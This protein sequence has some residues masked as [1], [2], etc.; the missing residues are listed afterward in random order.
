MVMHEPSARDLDRLIRM[1]IS[2]RD[3]L[4]AGAIGMAMV[5]SLSRVH[6]LSPEAVEAQPVRGGTLVYAIDNVGSSNDPGIFANFG[7]WEA[8][9]CICR[10]LTFFDYQ[11]PGSKPQPALA[12]R[13]EISGDGRSYTFSLRKGLKFHDGT[14]LTA[15]SVKRS[16]VRLLDEKDPTRAPGTYAGVEIGGDNIKE[17][18]IVDESTVRLI[19][20]EPDEAQLLRLA[21][22]NAVILS[23]AALDKYGAKIGL[24][25]VGAGPFKFERMA[26]GQEIVLSAFDGYYGGRPYLDR[27]VLRAIPN[28]ATMISALEAGQ[29]HA[30]NFAPVSALP[31]FRRNPNLKIVLGAP[32]IVLFAGLNAKIPPLDNIKVRQ[33]INYAINRQAIIE[34]VFNG[35]ALPPAGMIAPA[36][37]G[38]DGS[39]KT[40]SSYQPEKAKQLLKESGMANPE[41]TLQIVN[42]Q[43]WPRLV[44]LVQKD[45]T[46]VGFKVNVLKLDGGTFWGKVFDGKAEVSLTQRSAFVADPDNK[47]TPLLYSTSSVAQKQTGNDA[48]PD[49]KNLDGLLDQAR[50]Q[51]DPAKR[52]QEYAQIQKWLL[53]RVPYV[54]LCYE[55]QP[56]VMQKNVYAINTAALGT[57]RMYLEKAYIRPS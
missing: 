49:A 17:V 8:I 52:K 23:D 2:R 3:L 50:A 37:F 44:E 6:L 30:T 53:E 20:K 42:E 56:I 45:L 19:L 26:V 7:N 21:N 43:F 55:E 13:W 22:P 27:V 4:R 33:A 51:S 35:A 10:G 39:L 9:D 25:L 41:I 38:Y 11:G 15:Q 34:V 46:V 12:E 54:Y 32:Y 14:P 5:G 18:R 24:N 31:E 36:E 1:E 48:Y 57:Y 47:L 29:V 40:L 16:W 28:E